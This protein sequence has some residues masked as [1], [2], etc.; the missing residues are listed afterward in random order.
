MPPS[1]ERLVTAGERAIVLKP[2]I[3]AVTMPMPMNTLE[4]ARGESTFAS[5]R[6]KTR[7]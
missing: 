2:M 4:Q 5:I 6:L 1:D 3:R 7:N